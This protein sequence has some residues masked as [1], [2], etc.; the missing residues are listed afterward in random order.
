MARTNSGFSLLEL[1]IVVAIVGMLAA[2]VITVASSGRNK[3]ADARILNDV[4]Q[5]RWLAELAYESQGGTFVNWSTHPDI[6]ADLTILTNDINDAH[7][8][9]VTISIGETEIQNFCVSAPTKRNS[10]RHFCIDASREIIETNAAC[11]A[12]APHICP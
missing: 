6:A 1:I 7:Q 9:V 5:L 10:S 4:R 2:I 8:S 11:P 12:V 3:A